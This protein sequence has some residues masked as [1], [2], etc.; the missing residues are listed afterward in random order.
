MTEYLD[1]IMFAVLMVA[2]QS[3]FPVSFAIAGVAVG[4]AYLGLSVRRQD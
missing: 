2:I 1:L 4:F 3:G